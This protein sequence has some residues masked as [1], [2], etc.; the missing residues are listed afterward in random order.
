MSLISVDRVDAAV[1]GTGSYRPDR[2]VSNFEVTRLLEV[3][4][5]WVVARTGIRERRFA[6]DDETVA[7]M[8]VIAG[9]R[10]LS[11]ASISAI[12]IELVIVCSSTNYRSMPG[13]AAQVASEIGAVRAGAFDLNAVCAGF[14]YG[15]AQAASTVKDG[16]GPV[17][18]I[19]S[20]KLSDWLDPKDAGT[21]PIF[22]DGAGAVVIEASPEPGISPVV[23]GN[24][25]ARADLI[26]I[27]TETRV[28]EMKGPVVYKWAVSTLPGVVRAICE[29]AGL[30][31]DA[32]DWLVLHQANLRIVEAVAD[33]VGFPS[34]H[35][36]R[37]IV[38]SG[39]TSSASIPLALDAL[40]RSGDT[41]LGQ[42][43]LLLGF[44]S[45]LTF[46]GQIVRLPIG[47]SSNE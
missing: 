35:V 3:D 47:I 27:S 1:T 39:N 38:H 8:A 30:T 22:A 45:G 33:A 28:V 40:V 44:G 26:R 32:V 14:T 23:W 34:D 29:R 19:G 20:E 43:A 24:E 31:V 9:K 37:D 13:V 7:S 25:G 42:S 12:D 5:E 4:P 46:S 6:A 18:L 2:I 21:Y 36:S 17:L 11:A 10:A 41:R 16:R 15:L